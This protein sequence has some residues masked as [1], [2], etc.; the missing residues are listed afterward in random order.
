M[1]APDLRAAGFIL[2]GGQS[3]RMGQDKALL[4][5]CG[6]PLIAHAIAILRAAGLTA[7]IAGAH[8]PLAHFAPVTE[9]QADDRGSPRGPLSGICAALGSVAA[10][11]AA[12]LAVV[13]LAVDQPFVPPSLLIYLLHHARITGNAV[14]LATVAGVDQTFPVVLD[15]A[16]L[17]Y[18]R[19]ELESGQRGCLRAF[20][21][22][23]AQLNQSVSRIP[24]E[25][26][27]QSGQ[28]AHPAGLGAAHWLTNLNTPATLRRSLALVGRRIA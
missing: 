4:N 9:D 21:A 10:D 11:R 7:S 6:T 20:A 23:A 17:P 12:F 1:S 16:A 27:A 22:A 24:I 14:T 18:L 3:R 25:L 19:A 8:A 13:F 26:L 2:A 15:R 5:F 28:V